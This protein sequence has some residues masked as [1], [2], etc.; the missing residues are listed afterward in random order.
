MSIL[1]HVTLDLPFSNQ[2]LA[3][4]RLPPEEQAR[5]LQQQQ[6]TQNQMTG[7]PYPSL[8]QTYDGQVVGP[9]GFPVMGG[10]EFTPQ[11]AQGRHL[12]SLPYQQGSIGYPQPQM[13][14][15]GLPATGIGGYQA[16]V[17]GVP[18]FGRRWG[19]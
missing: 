10:Y 13:G 12:G 11:A 9:N 19:W 5:F 8:P 4:A 17:M 18:T 6:E 1:T 3:L 7:H 16:G 14:Y 15:T 2:R